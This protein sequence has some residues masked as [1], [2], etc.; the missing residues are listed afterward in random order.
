MND[1]QADIKARYETV[2]WSNCCHGFCFGFSAISEYSVLRSGLRRFAIMAF[3]DGGSSEARGFVRSQIIGLVTFDSLST[4]WARLKRK[5]ETLLVSNARKHGKLF[6]FLEYTPT[7][8][9]GFFARSSNFKFN[10]SKLVLIDALKG[11]KFYSFPRGLISP[12]KRLS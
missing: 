12:E 2:E 11:K 7:W 4:S 10:K 8:D 6:Q 9:P 3:C 5:Q 1:F